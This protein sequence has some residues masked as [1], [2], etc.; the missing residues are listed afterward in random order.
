VQLW[1]DSQ[2]PVLRRQLPERVIA[3]HVEVAGDDLLHLERHQSKGFK[4]LKVVGRTLLLLALGHSAW[5]EWAVIAHA[6]I[7]WGVFFGTFFISFALSAI[8]AFLPA[9]Q[10][11]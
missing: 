9:K 11:Q 3:Q 8:L 5:V 6:G 1:K 2:R 10:S 7:V 4:V